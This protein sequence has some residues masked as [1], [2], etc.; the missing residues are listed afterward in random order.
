[1]HDGWTKKWKTKSLSG[2]TCIHISRKSNCTLAKLWLSKQKPAQLLTVSK[3]ISFKIKC[4][5][6]DSCQKLPTFADEI[7]LIPYRICNS[8]IFTKLLIFRLFFWFQTKIVQLDNARVKLQV[9]TKLRFLLTSTELMCSN[10]DNSLFLYALWIHF[11]LDL[12]YW[13]V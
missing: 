13:W 1:M 2:L 10:I 7:H 5:S 4:N 3:N 11:T 8:R 9:C 6:I 12:G